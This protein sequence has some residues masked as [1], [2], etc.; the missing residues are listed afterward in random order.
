[1]SLL[2]S[3]QLGVFSAIA[4]VLWLVASV[5][6][7]YGFTDADGGWTPERYLL[8]ATLIA[9]ACLLTTAV[10]I[11][12]NV[13]A[14][15]RV[16]RVRPS[17]SRSIGLVASAVA[18]GCSGWAVTLWMPAPRR[19]GD[20]DAAARTGGHTPASRPFVVVLLVA[21][22]AHRDRLDRASAVRVID[23][24]APPSELARLG[25]SSPAWRAVLVSRV[26]WT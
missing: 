12:V 9:A 23:H 22:A 14:D 21:D 24:R 20:V 11:G 26:S 17:R 10:L 3:R 6:A 5:A 18:S 15:R 7:F 4:A 16:R 13:R 8:S 19:R 2:F 25:C 1:M